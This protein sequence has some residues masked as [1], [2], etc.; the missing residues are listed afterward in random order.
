MLATHF[1]ANM[2]NTFVDILKITYSKSDLHALQK[3]I[4][5][6]I[7]KLVHVCRQKEQSLQVQLENILI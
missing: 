7:D 6:L 3:L 2:A 5:M 4:I 1:N